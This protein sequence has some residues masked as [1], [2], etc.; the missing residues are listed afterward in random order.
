MLSL[1]TFLLITVIVS[2]GDSSHRKTLSGQATDAAGRGVASAI[3]L[4]S[5]PQEGPEIKTKTSTDGHFRLVRLQTGTYKVCLT[6]PGFK[7][8]CVDS[9][10]I[11]HRRE[12]K[13][14]NITLGLE[15]CCGGISITRQSIEI[16]QKSLETTIPY[17]EPKS[18]KP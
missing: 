9:V 13:L 1:P 8:T 11:S 15:Q 3:A 16:E 14:G 4:I 17:V 10:T 6:S 2:G 18:P 12:T 5:I 7:T